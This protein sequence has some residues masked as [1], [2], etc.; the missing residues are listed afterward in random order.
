[1]NRR[2]WLW[3]A[4]LA[5]PLGVAG[6]L[7]ADSQA[8]TYVCPITGEPLQ[9]EKCCPLNQSKQPTQE[10]SFI[11]PVTGEDLPCQKCCPLNDSK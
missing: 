5:L 9:C 4:L 7:Y 6:G 10:Q 1:M 3:T 11:C 8:R 2:K